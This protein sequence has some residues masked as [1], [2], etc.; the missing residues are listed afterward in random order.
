MYSAWSPLLRAKFWKKELVGSGAPRRPGAKKG[1]GSGR[2]VDSA[3]GKTKG[4]WGCGGGMA[5]GGGGG[6]GGGN[7]GGGGGEGGGL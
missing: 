2:T 4:N 3:R 6:G 1:E 5:A 7:G